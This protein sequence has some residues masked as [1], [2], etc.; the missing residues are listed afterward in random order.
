[1]SQVESRKSYDPRLLLFYAL[2][3]GML[4]ILAGGLAFRQLMRTDEYIE[5]EKVQNQ[6]RVAPE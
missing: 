4:L 2:L 6:R 3:S 5:R 1:M